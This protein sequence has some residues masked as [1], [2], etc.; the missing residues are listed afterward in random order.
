MS[1]LRF[2]GYEFSY[3]PKTITI[4]Q[5]KRILSHL[6]PQSKSVFQQ[7]MGN[8]PIEIS[9]EG[10]LFGENS[11]KSFFEI[12]SL[13]QSEESGILSLPHFKPTICFLTEIKNVK[14]AGPNLLT[15]SFKFVEDV[16]KRGEAL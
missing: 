7:P 1:K 16:S 10:E 13:F 8:M 9:G 14:T 6:L 5:E 2:K 12:Y 3:N 11:D 4:K 15:Y